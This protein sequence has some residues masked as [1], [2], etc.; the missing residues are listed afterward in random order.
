MGHIAVT[1]AQRTTNTFGQGGWLGPEE[2]TA[3][4]TTF[5]VEWVN[6]LTGTGYFSGGTAQIKVGP[7]PPPGDLL[8][9]AVKRCGQTSVSML[10][11]KPLT[12]RCAE[13][14]FGAQLQFEAKGVEEEWRSSISAVRDPLVGLGHA[15]DY[16]A[17]SHA[18]DYN[19][20]MV[21]SAGRARGL[22]E[23][24]WRENRHLWSTYAPEAFGIQV[25]TKAHLDRATN[26]SAWQV[27]A[28]G[29]NRYLVEAHDL[30]PWYSTPEPSPQVRAE[31]RED[32]GDILLTD[33]AVRADAHGW[34]RGDPR[35]DLTLN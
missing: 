21:Q 3:E 30:A 14:T 28:I 9:T 11:L 22:R 25:L 10:S 27:T 8:A 1:Q 6:A 7:T 34:V 16:A 18:V 17:V 2:T 13:L 15:A 20:G 12:E 32:F 4:V 29:D 23:L 19:V 33:A 31:A 26:L 24:V 5:A 35:R